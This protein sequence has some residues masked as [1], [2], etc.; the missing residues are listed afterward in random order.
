MYDDD[1]FIT[2]CDSNTRWMLPWFEERFYKH[3]PNGQLKV[4]DFDKE[5]LNGWMNKPHAMLKASGMGR[6]RVC[7]LDTDCEIRSDI[8]DIF[9][10]TERNKLLMGIDQP[11]STRSY[12]TW[13]NTG[14]VAFQCLPDIPHILSDW[15]KE[16]VTSGGT[17]RGDQELLHEML[18]INLNRLIYIT[19]LPK[20]YN[21]LRLDVMDNTAPRNI[22]IM[23]H[24]GPKGKLEI[25]RQMKT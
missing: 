10:Y 15:A 2:G 12:E 23:H 25:K 1:L 8:S 11:W 7:W 13:H 16:A 21:T 22:K 19:H 14:V 3:V 17:F 9:E 6:K 24:T 18:K 20:G 5:E 4:F